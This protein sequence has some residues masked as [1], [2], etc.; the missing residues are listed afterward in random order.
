MRDEYIKIFR[1]VKKSNKN[2]S[3]SHSLSRV[4]ISVQFIHHSFLSH[5]AENSIA[6]GIHKS[7]KKSKFSL[8]KMYIMNKQ[9]II[10]ILI[11]L[12]KYKL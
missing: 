4:M 1:I 5:L 2:C 8:R 3:Y 12:T 9:R 7:K 6:L 11:I 10:W